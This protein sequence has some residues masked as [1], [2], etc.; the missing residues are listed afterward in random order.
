MRPVA[1]GGIAA[2]WVRAPQVDR[3]PRGEAG[4]AVCHE[5]GGRSEVRGAV[6]PRD[7]L[8]IGARVDAVRGCVSAPLVPL[9]LRVEGLVVALAGC[10]VR[11]IDAQAVQ[12][13]VDV[14]HD[15]LHV[16]VERVE[17]VECA[18]LD[19]EV[20]DATYGRRRGGEHALPTVLRASEHLRRG[21]E[22][23]F[24]ER[25]A[26]GACSGHVED[27]RGDA[28]EA[29]P[30]RRERVRVRGR[31]SDEAHDRAHG[32]FE[33]SQSLWVCE[34]SR[35][36]GVGEALVDALGRGLAFALLDDGPE[37]VPDVDSCEVAGEDLLG[38][39]RATLLRNVSTFKSIALDF[40]AKAPLFIAICIAA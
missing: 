8:T 28:Y 40:F 19:D 12:A 23:P 36:G 37:G 34:D 20:A 11:W 16:G 33:V 13:V 21:F 32:R 31:E 1:L 29:L 14:L 39:V 35:V 30:E 24:P 38:D 27:G 9:I 17:R 26:L 15:A 5:V 25:R 7:A 18:A 10:V 2:L 6:A 22:Q 3:V 4:G